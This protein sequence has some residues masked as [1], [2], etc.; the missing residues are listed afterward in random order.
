M[1][2]KDAGVR[3]ALPFFGLLFCALAHADCRNYSA[4]FISGSATGDNDT[5]QV[6]GQTPDFCFDVSFSAGA[7]EHL[8]GSDDI[9][10]SAQKD[11]SRTLGEVAQLTTV[12][13][14]FAPVD[15]DRVEL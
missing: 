7:R 4:A 14:G 6:L 9:A 12:L 1:N 11:L 2:R 8:S 5:K 15:L 13:K 3:V 10:K